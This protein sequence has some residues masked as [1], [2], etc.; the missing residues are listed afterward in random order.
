MVGPRA[1]IA[2]TD[3]TVSGPGADSSTTGSAEI[4]MNLEPPESERLTKLTG[5]NAKLRAEVR[6]A[7]A[8]AQRSEADAARVRASTKFQ[9]GDL[10]VKAA[11]HPRRALLL[12]RDLLRLYR[13]R[14][15]RRSQP[16]AEENALPPARMRR[17]D[18]TDEIAARLL[19]PR[20]AQRLDRPLSIA[21][22]LALLRAAVWAPSA[23]VTQVLPHDAATLTSEVDPDVVVIDGLSAEPLGTWSHLGNPAATDRAI[24]AES[25]LDAA[26]SNGRPLVLI[27]ARA[28]D[29]GLDAIA[30]RCD[31]VLD[32][33]GASRRNPWQPGIDLGIVAHCAPW[34]LRDDGDAPAPTAVLAGPMHAQLPENQADIAVRDAWTDAAGDRGVRLST[35]AESLPGP[36]GFLTALGE[37]GVVALT[38]PS[39][40]QMVGAASIALAALACG[41]PLVSP[42]DQDIDALLDSAGVA[43]SWPWLTYPAGDAEAAREALSRAW[44]YRPVDKGDL[45]QVWRA[46]F[47]T[48]TPPATWTQVMTQLGLSTRP[49]SVRD[50]AVHLPSHL[51]GGDIGPSTIVDALSRQQLRPREILV[52][53]EHH[54][55]LRAALDDRGLTDLPLRL[56]APD[57]SASWVR[58]AQASTS[59]L[60]AEIPDS[61]WRTLAPLA[62]QDLVIAYEVSNRSPRVSMMIPD[63]SAAFA[64][65]ARQ[66]A[67]DS[68]SSAAESTP[69]HHPGWWR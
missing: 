17:T 1:E 46:L 13:L 7:L 58:A 34:L 63:D 56:L 16:A 20:V 36:A 39:S 65:V 40:P 11:R 19:L 12:P 44:N 33:P 43:D 8:R 52:S 6:Q 31:L 37:A 67:L 18:Y 10:L 22:A 9:V 21:G 32:G 38:G 51:I 27:R 4:E 30:D 47:S 59:A 2:M 14:R 42:H 61:A 49:Q 48:A 23:A 5:E 68:H 50:V 64:I 54:S 25:L 55:T 41:R 15:H 57:S 35:M 28:S 24:A 26:K 69:I 66:G 60:I 53:S 62:L 45:W 29:A 3:S